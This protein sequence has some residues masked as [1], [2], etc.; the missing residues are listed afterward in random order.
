MVER[1]GLSI[2][3]VALAGTAAALEEK[4]I[5]TIVDTAG[6]TTELRQLRFFE[7]ITTVD[8]VNVDTGRLI[9]IVPDVQLESMSQ[10]DKARFAVSYDSDGKTL[11]A[12]GRLTSLTTPDRA[13]VEVGGETDRGFF[14]IG[15]DRIKT[16]RFT[17][18]PRVARPARGDSSTATAT[19]TLDDGS[20]MAVKGLERLARFYPE[21]G[22]VNMLISASWPDI[23]IVRNG[24]TTVVS[25]TRIAKVDFGA[26]GEIAVTPRDGKILSGKVGSGKEGIEGFVASGEKGRF[27][28]DRKHVVSVTFTS[29][30]G[31]RTP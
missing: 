5:A 27:F 4:R 31:R 15:A 14:R 11:V 19:L 6:E 22:I 1:L 16:L 18:G 21:V 2:L 13:V 7:G 30:P 17:K 26:G 29:S 10:I 25:M 3:V 23:P 20:S 9:V 24:E 12:E 28:V 8:T